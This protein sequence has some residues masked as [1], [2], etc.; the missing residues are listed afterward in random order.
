[1]MMACESNGCFENGRSE[2]VEEIYITSYTELSVYGM[3]ELILVSDTMDYVEFVTRESVLEHLKATVVD[4]ILLLDNSNNC[5]YQRDYKKVKAY[6]HYK[7]LRQINLHEACKLTS[8]YPLENTMDLT[9]QSEM[10]EVDIEINAERFFFYN[11]RTT[12]GKYTFRGYADYANI[13]GYYTA[14]FIM[15]ELVVRDLVLNNSSISD[16]YVNPIEKLEVE[17]HHRGNVYYTGSP[18]IIIDSIT[19]S[20]QLIHVE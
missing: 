10:A 13:S 14:Q 19:G 5:F 11:N 2:V 20:G 1:M 6:I 12:G 4:E 18:E 17:I 15:K 3:F 9:I 8:K 7:S 16:M